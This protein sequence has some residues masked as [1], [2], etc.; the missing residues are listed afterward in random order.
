MD[1][2]MLI[3]PSTALFVL[4][5]HLHLTSFL[6]EGREPDPKSGSGGGS[7]TPSAWKI[8]ERDFQWPRHNT[9]DMNTEPRKDEA[10]VAMV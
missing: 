6:P 5:T 3:C 9:V 1:L 4:Q 10:L 7:C 8:P 2:Y